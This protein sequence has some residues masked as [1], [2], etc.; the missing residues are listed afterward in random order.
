[1]T[2]TDTPYRGAKYVSTVNWAAQPLPDPERFL[3]ECFALTDLIF[4]VPPRRD[5]HYKG[6]GP[7]E[8]LR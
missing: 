1:M 5:N 7:E 6:L 8:T 4:G 2:D 3:A